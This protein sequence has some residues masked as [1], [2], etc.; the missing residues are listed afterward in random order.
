M[1]ATRFG[2][3]LTLGGIGAISATD[4]DAIVCCAKEFAPGYNS[5]DPK[6]L[7]IVSDR[8]FGDTGPIAYYLRLDD[9]RTEMQRPEQRRLVQMGANTIKMH[10]DKGHRVLVHCAQG[11]NRSALVLGRYFM[12]PPTRLSGKQAVAL[13]KQFRP[14]TFSNAAF[15][16]YLVDLR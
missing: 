12:L 8:P 2:N 9:S 5:R 6:R 3:L 13:I 10:V 16:K 14:Q 1:S 4:Y 11:I 7:A 15:A